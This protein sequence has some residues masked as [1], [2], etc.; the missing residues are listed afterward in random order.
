MLNDQKSQRGVSL[1]IAFMVLALLLSLALGIS[2][3]L[4]SQ[5]KIL[6]GVGYSV[7]AFAAA[8]TG[9]ERV[10]EID[11]SSCIDSETIEER[12]TCIRDA[13]N[14]L[15]GSEL[16]LSNGATFQ[17]T[18]EAAGEGGCPVSKNYCIR[19]AGLYLEARRSIRAGR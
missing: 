8:E 4:I 1:Y 10:L 14:A 13:V 12:I 11:A 19:S 16:E 3:I 5:I 17:V 15:P 6:R 7:L 18:I 2:T 9:V